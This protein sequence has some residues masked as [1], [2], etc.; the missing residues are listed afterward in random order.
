MSYEFV[1]VQWSPSH[2][3]LCFSSSCVPYFADFSGLS[4]FIA[5][6]AING[7]YAE[8]AAD[9]TKWNPETKD[10]KV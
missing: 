1:C 5:S 3:L 7:S 8:I 2:V 4:F 10:L 9:I 6:S